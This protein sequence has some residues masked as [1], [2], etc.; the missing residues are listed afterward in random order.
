MSEIFENAVNSIIL[1]IEDFET[2][3]DKRMLSAARNYYAGLLLLA[4]EC[5]I[6]AAPDAEPMEVIGAKFEPEPDGD[7]GV[8]HTVK[9]Y[10]TVD[11]A[12]LKS[13]F[14]NFNLKW[15]DANI[16]KLQQ[17]R[18]DLE[19]YHF[20][21]PASALGEAI[22]S[23]FPMVVD[24]FT[25]LEESPEEHLAEVWD[26]ILNEHAAFQKVQSACIA[27]LQT[28]EWPAEVEN[29][30]L[31]ACPN[32]K[33]SLV[34]QRD[35]ENSVSADAVGKCYQCST[36]I[37]FE[38]MMMVVVTASYE[39][40]AYI[41][42]KEGLNPSIT[43]CPECTVDAYVETGDISV[44]FVCNASFSTE[45]A[46]CGTNIDVYEYNYAMPEFCGYCARQIEKIMD[47]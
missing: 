28:I 47:E 27:S 43:Q 31:L 1:G 15:P 3:T 17:F 36:E 33:S 9:G 42:A 30:D 12:Q 4:K 24:F 38:Q 45:C 41:R 18:N 7:G 11:L 23:S 6:K 46:R 13:R 29:L 19:H 14:K 22:A 32:C 8:R 21:E 35:P 40:D 2:G 5:L 39:V 34:G 10:N 37:E 25:I 44:C 26:T 20:R 16:S